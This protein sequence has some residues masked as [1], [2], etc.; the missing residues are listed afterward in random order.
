MYNVRLKHFKDG[1]TQARLYSHPV[2][3]DYVRS[4]PAPPKEPYLICEPF[5]GTMCEVVSD[6]DE[7]ERKKERSMLNSLKRSKQKIYDIARANEWEYFITLT[8]DPIKVDRYDYDDCTK[9]LIK[10]L[11]NTKQRLNPD[12]RYLIVPERHKDGAF[13]FHG[14]ISACEGLK[15][16][17]SGRYDKK[18]SAIY[19]IG[20]YGLGFTTATKVQNNAAVTKYITKYTTKELVQHLKGKRKYWASR[21]C[22]NPIVEDF[23]L[24]RSTQGLLHEELIEDAQAYKTVGYYAGTQRRQVSYYESPNLTLNIEEGDV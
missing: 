2:R 22:D 24:D 4:S 1:E 10:W 18:G 15:I 8:F 20:S 6:F 12:F 17:P 5:E 13:H 14:L 23:L 3:T 11:S 9:K 21:N 19:N 7:K 16:T